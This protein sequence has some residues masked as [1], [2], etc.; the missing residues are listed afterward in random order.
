MIQAPSLPRNL[1]RHRCRNNRHAFLE[2]QVEKAFCIYW[3]E[4][5]IRGGQQPSGLAGIYN[6]QKICPIDPFQCSRQLILRNAGLFH[7]LYGEFSL[8]KSCVNIAWKQEE[9]AIN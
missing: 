2:R 9:L 7:H 6:Q 4:S 8:L 3:A 1:V 5:W